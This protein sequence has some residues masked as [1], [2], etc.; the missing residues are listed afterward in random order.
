[1]ILIMR[2]STKK[3]TLTR[4]DLALQ[5]YNRIGYSHLFSRKMVDFVFETIGKKLKKNYQ[6]KLTGF[7]NFTIRK[8]QARPGRNPKTGQALVIKAHKAL[9]FHP[10][11]VFRDYVNRKRK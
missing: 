1:M 2:Q 11:R 6:V 5:V 8:K 10:G 7:G 4:D 9:V 3:T